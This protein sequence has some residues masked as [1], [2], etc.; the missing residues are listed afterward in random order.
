MG[1]SVRRHNGFSTFHRRRVR[2]PNTHI[3]IINK[4]RNVMKNLKETKE[5]IF[6]TTIHISNI[7]KSNEMSAIC[8]LYKKQQELVATPAIKRESKHQRSTSLFKRLYRGT[9]QRFIKANY[10]SCTLSQS[11]QQSCK[12]RKN[13]SF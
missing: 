4:K 3:S 7:L 9:N 11:I 1:N 5:Q 2:F 10:E 8:I 6:A 12:K 13:K